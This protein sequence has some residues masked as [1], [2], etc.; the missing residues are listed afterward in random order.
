MVAKLAMETRLWILQ[1]WTTTSRR[2][3]PLRFP[4]AVEKIN[5]LPLMRLPKPECRSVHCNGLLAKHVC[6][7]VP[8]HPSLQPT[9]TRAQLICWG[10][11]TKP[12]GL[13]RVQPTSNSPCAQFAQHGTTCAGL[14]PQM[15][16]FK[17]EPTQ[18]HKVVLSSSWP[19]PRSWKAR[20]CLTQ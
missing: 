15:L 10:S 4:K 16:L 6:N 9:S 19:T 11:S 14:F 3:C 13:K 5:L 2:R 17:F 20:P 12:R 1:C 18:A 7:W 8:Q